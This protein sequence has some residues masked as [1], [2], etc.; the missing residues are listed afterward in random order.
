M[1]SVAFDIANIIYFFTKQRGG[2][3]Y[4]AIPFS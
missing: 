3:P 2:Q 1:K 4:W